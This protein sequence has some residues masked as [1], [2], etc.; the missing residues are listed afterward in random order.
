MARNAN[1]ISGRL[2]ATIAC[3]FV[4]YHG[5]NIVEARGTGFSM[6]T[7]TLNVLEK[8]AEMLFGHQNTVKQNLDTTAAGIDERPDFLET[9]DYVRN[10]GG[11]LVKQAKHL[12]AND[13]NFKGDTFQKLQDAIMARKEEQS[14]QIEMVHKQRKQKEQSVQ[15]TQFRQSQRL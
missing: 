1:A 2:I 9:L 4:Y 10:K 5:F 8:S 14:E 11:D 13:S 6:L 3:S 12:T 15:I 7:D